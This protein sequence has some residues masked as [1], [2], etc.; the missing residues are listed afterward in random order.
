MQKRNLKSNKGK[1][2]KEVFL[3]KPNIFEDERGFFY[4]SCNLIELKNILSREVYFNQDNHSFSKKGVLR[5]IHYQLNPFPQAKLI[6]CV[7]GI[8]FDVAVD[9]RKNSETFGE[10]VSAE[11]SEHNHE[12]LWIPEGF[13]HGYL[14]ISS[15]AIVL[16]KATNL[17]NKDLERCIYWDDDKI[18]INWPFEKIKNMRPILSEKDSSAINIKEAINKNQIF[19]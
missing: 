18:N 16:Y 8:I 7:K 12:Q 15:E 1:N 14:T 13:G 19:K 3:L 2:I 9:L 11:L 10:W 5:G 4:E 6:R 17:W